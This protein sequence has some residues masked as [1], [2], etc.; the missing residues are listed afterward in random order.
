MDPLCP[1]EQRS[2]LSRPLFPLGVRLGGCP[3]ELDPNRSSNNA[4]PQHPRR[5]FGP[6]V[7]ECDEAGNLL[8]RCIAPLWL[9]V[10]VEENYPL[11]NFTLEVRL[12]VEDVS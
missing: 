2:L 12:G 7:L 6:P 10:L 11:G 9:R 1:L 3:V 8:L 5:K 4:A